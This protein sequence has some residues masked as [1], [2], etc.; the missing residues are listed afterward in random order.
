VHDEL[1]DPATQ[2]R[3]ARDLHAEAMRAM[4][5]TRDNE[6][7][8]TSQR[9]VRILEDTARR[10]MSM[11]LVDEPINDAAAS[12][13]ERVAL[14]RRWTW[15]NPLAATVLAVVGVAVS[16]GAAVLGG[17]S[18]NIVLAVIGGL[19]GSALVGVVVLR[20]RRENWRIKAEKIAPMIWRPGL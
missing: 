19:I 12:M 10:I 18:D 11:Q 7:V 5:V 15:V 9:Q 4:S 6:T 2:G 13:L 17:T 20:Y 1:A 3:I 16:V 8:I 14:A